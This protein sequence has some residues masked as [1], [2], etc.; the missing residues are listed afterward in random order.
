[1]CTNSWQFPN[2]LCFLILYLLTVDFYCHCFC[3]KACYPQT[4]VP[5]LHVTLLGGEWSSSAG[6]LSTI[7]RELAIHLSN[8]SAVKVSLLVPKGGCNFEEIREAHTYGITVVEAKRRAAFDRLDWLSS[9]PKDH[10]M[11]IVVGHG[12]KLGRQVQFIRDCS[13]SKL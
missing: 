3:I 11:D 7:N 10:V 6:G 9:P 5:V 12:V 8:H 4:S 2:L 1:M 13:I